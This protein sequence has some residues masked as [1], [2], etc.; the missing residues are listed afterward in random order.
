METLSHYLK[1]FQFSAKSFLINSGAALLCVIIL[2][3]HGKAQDTFSIV[4]VDT[5]TG[6]IGSAGASCVTSSTTYPHGAA[7]LSD[8]IP[9]IGAIHTQAAW[10]SVNQTNAHARMIAGDSP[11]E[12]IDWLVANDAQGNPTTRQYGIVDFRNNLPRAA[13]YTGIN[14][15]SYK[16][17]TAGIFYSIQGNILLGQSIIDSMQDRFLTT[18]GTL[19]D[20]L[21]A[22][23][24]GAKVIGADTR[25]APRNSS[26][27][28]A[29]LRVARKT[30]SPDSLYIDLWMA[31]PQGFSGLA[32]VDPVDS[33]QT[34][35]DQWKTI[36]S[37]IA[38]GDGSGNCVRITKGN[39]GNTALD[40]SCFPDLQKLKLVI[41]DFTGR[42][43]LNMPVTSPVIHPFSTSQPRHGLYF[44]QVLNQDKRMVAR[45]KFFS[46]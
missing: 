42:I 38:G 17:D 43:V 2:I 45:G 5:L 1:V 37:V 31:Y 36:T 15:L 25:C 19:G 10:N 41:F 8:L 32:P 46:L 21:M 33:L 6:E 39:D 44:Y 22:A 12:I 23:L 27:L 18:Q 34:L 28:S 20:R 29:F 3:S 24:Q 14:C 4:A 13:A 9:G 35:Y 40:F 26:S 16:N 7:I 30:N 11:Q